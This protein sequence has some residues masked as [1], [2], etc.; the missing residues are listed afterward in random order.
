MVSMG[1]ADYMNP[2]YGFLKEAE[3]KGLLTVKNKKTN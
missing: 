2:A 3:S 1:V